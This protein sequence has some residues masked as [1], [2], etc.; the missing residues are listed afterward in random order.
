[1]CQFE[2]AGGNVDEAE[3]W[4]NKMLASGS[5][6]QLES[7]KE[8]LRA[9]AANGRLTKME[10]WFAKA[11]SPALYPEMN[12]FQLDAACYNIVALAFA[13]AGDTVRSEQYA[14]EMQSLG[15]QIN[16]KCY[17]ALARCYLQKNDPRRAHAW[18]LEM[19]EGAGFKK[20]NKA[21]L[22]E[23]IRSLADQGNVSSAN[24][25]LGYMFDNNIRADD[26]TYDYVRRAHPAIIIPTQL[27]GESWTP[28][29]PLIKPVTL[30]GEGIV[31]RELKEKVWAGPKHTPRHHLS[32]LTERE[33]RSR[34]PLAPLKGPSSARITSPSKT[35]MLLPPLESASP[36]AESER[37]MATTS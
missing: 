7:L 25:W 23:V 16:Q 17:T 4:M 13:E 9:W 5:D 20:P 11:A 27:S 12:L 29:P 14:R 19:V 22:L 28:V 2:S 35:T 26:E 37:G 10:E 33:R 8:L 34:R 3:A 31:R 6:P 24:K 30:N 21:V 36:G 15:F 18:C 32:S 1:M